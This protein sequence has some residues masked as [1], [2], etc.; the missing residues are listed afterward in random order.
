V[1]AQEVRALAGRSATAAK[2]IKELIS[3]SVERVRAGNQLVERAGATMDEIVRSTASVTE[4]I[5]RIA[6]ASQEQSSGIDA[7]SHT[8]AQMD[9]ATRQNAAAVE[10]A[11][12]AAGKMASEAQALSESVQVFKLRG[13]STAARAQL[14]TSRVA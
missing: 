11:A 9:E 10:E 13:G 8:I 5:G 14:P 7:V 3:A 12:G 1:V 6:N 2:E 4:I